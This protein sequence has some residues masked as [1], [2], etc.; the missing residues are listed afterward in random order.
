MK[1]SSAHIDQVSFTTTNRLRVAVGLFHLSIEHQ[2]A[3][4]TLVEHGLIGSACALYRPQFEA[5][6]RATWYQ[7]C[8]TEQQLQAFV[9]G[10]EPPKI[11]VLLAG[12]DACDA[13]QGSP[14]SRIKN[15]LWKRLNDFTHGGA[16]QVGARVSERE[17]AR[18]YPDRVICGLLDSSA[19]MSFLAGVGIAAAANN[20]S[21]ATNLRNDHQ[22]IYGWAE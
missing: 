16:T 9:G 7:R 2:M 5:L 15:R 8:A 19:I 1:C 21:L 14:L 18:N 10:N 3:I 17:I 12:I 20:E 11:T 13:L 4:H 22:R 6:V